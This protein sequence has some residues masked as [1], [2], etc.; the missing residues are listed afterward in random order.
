MND[1]SEIFSNIRRFSPSMKGLTKRPLY[2]Q[3]TKEQLKEEWKKIQEGL[4]RCVHEL[5]DSFKRECELLST[6]VYEAGGDEEA[7]QLLSNIVHE[8]DTERAVK[9]NS[10][11]LERLGI[12]GL[13]DSLGV[14]NISSS[15]EGS[16]LALGQEEYRNLVGRA[17]LGITGADYG[18]ADTGTLVLRTLPGQDRSSSVLPPVHVSILESGR[19]L[20]SLDDLIT[21]L[22][23]DHEVAGELGSCITLITGASKTADIELNLVL[24]IHGPKDLR[25]ILLR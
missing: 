1:R 5:V 17:D 3:G 6:K 21:R 24:G 23:L 12:D 22:L 25:V 15:G 10:P 20:S 9:W 13:L 19:M 7:R 8:T 4:G 18:I 11:F 16:L 14:Q 2:G